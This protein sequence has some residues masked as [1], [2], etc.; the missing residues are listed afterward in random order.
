MSA[1]GSDSA[2][3]PIPSENSGASESPHIAHDICAALRLVG[4]VPNADMNRC[5]KRCREVWSF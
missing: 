2:V 3:A 5:S 4:V 1:P